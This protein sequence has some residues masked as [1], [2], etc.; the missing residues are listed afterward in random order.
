[1]TRPLFWALGVMV[2]ACLSAVTFPERATRLLGLAGFEE[3]APVATSTASGRTLVLQADYHGQ[4]VAH[5]GVNGAVIR[6]LVDTGASLVAL[7]A[8]DAVKAGVTV[9]SS[10][11]RVRFTTANGVVE[12]PVVRLAA[13]ELGGIVVRDVEAAV[14][15]KG[16]MEGTLLGM[17]F[18]RAVAGFEVSKG[19]LVIKG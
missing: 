15:P 1:M 2:G 17:S 11:R 8:E 16:A 3:A 9:R 4:F 14:M 12:A 18:L 6:A 5:V 10:D 7:S 13:V 19:R